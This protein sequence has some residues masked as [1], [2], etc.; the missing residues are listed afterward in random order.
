MSRY[1]CK[2]GLF[3][4][5][6]CEENVYGVNEPSSNNGWIYTAFSAYLGYTIR[7]DNLHELYLKCQHSVES[8]FIITRLP[9]KQEPPISRDELIGMLSLGMAEFLPKNNWYYFDYKEEVKPINQIKAA[10]SLRG[11]HR[12]HAW[13]EKVTNAYPVVFRLWF[14]DVY[15]AKKMLNIKPTIL[16]FILFNLYA[17]STILKFKKSTSTLSEKNILWLQLKDLNSRVLIR[18]VNQKRN[19]LNYF[20]PHHDFTR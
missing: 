12:N 4:H 7:I 8:P 19:F 18:F 10:L 9:G 13:T 16:E 20:G 3:H 14:W 6:E 2:Y 1:I 17:L 11:K 15:Y 5:K